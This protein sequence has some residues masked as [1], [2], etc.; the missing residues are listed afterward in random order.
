M[1]AKNI[2]ELII[3]LGPPKTATTSLQTFF[4]KLDHPEIVYGGV[5]QPWKTTKKNSIEKKLYAAITQNE[6]NSAKE[7]IE[8]I[9]YN[10]EKG[11][12]VFISDEMFL[13][14]TKETVDSKLRKLFVLL[15]QFNPMVL[16]VTREPQAVIESYFGEICNKIE[17]KN[18]ESFAESSHC[19][20]YK[21]LSLQKK[22]L[23]VGYSKIVFLHYKKL[24]KG[25]Y[26]L[27][28][29]FSFLKKDM[30]IVLPMKNISKTKSNH[31]LAKPMSLRYFISRKIRPLKKAPILK[32]LFGR[33][34]GRIIPSVEINQKIVKKIGLEK[35]EDF[36]REYALI[37]HETEIS[38]P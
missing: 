5:A 31:R 9:K 22:I 33:N 8:E 32:N 20:I 7:V 10:L 12:S 24:V 18:I 6:P 36:N 29:I 19:E 37:D 1:S 35:F 15:S 3:H 16:L 4:H 14:K 38:S 23:N 2:G 26:K 30:D 28:D 17:I 34:L 11:K 21:Y 13:V 27:S 25:N